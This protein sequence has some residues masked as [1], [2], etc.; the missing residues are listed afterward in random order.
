MGGILTTWRILNGNSMPD[1]RQRNSIE[2]WQNPDSYRKRLKLLSSFSAKNNSLA[3]QNLHYKS[4]RI[5]NME[6]KMTSK[7]IYICLMQNVNAKLSYS[8][9]HESIWFSRKQ[10][11]QWKQMNEARS[12][13]LWQFKSG[14][15]LF[16][17]H[18][19]WQK[20]PHTGLRH[21]Y[22]IFI[23]ADVRSS[24]LLISE[25]ATGILHGSADDFNL[26]KLHR[27]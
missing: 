19:K 26:A 1:C 7:F 17:S 5:V 13:S 22:L 9:E 8:A 25:F 15:Q 23:V 2:H 21:E 12:I 24:L 27:E 4:H 11:N 10:T 3:C 14:H 18:N 16:R 20:I 6:N